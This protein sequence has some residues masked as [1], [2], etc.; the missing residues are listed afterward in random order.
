MSDVL[1][2]EKVDDRELRRAYQKRSTPAAT[3]PGDQLN[4]G[5]R[6][7]L[8]LPILRAEN[9]GD[10]PDSDQTQCPH[11]GRVWKSF[12]RCAARTTS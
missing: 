5:S 8:P 4:P 12:R 3:P 9:P 2:P 6:A 10:E 11:C 1:W 7:F